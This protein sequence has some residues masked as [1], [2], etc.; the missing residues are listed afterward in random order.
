MSRQ[1]KPAHVR[2][3]GSR[4]YAKPPLTLNALLQRLKARGLDVPDEDRAIY[5]VSGL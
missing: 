3:R 5:H 4:I 2:Q 1:D